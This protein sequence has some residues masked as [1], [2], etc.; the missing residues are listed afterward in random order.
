MLMEELLCRCEK[1]GIPEDAIADIKVYFAEHLPQYDPVDIRKKSF[2][3]DDAH[4]Y[5]VAARKK[6]G[7]AYAVWTGWNELLKTLNHGHYDLPDL[8][9]CGEIMDDFYNG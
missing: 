8:N 7:K 6:D 2:H 4:L 9:A 3:P 1:N 5:M